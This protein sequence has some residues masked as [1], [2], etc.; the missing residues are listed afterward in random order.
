MEGTLYASPL[1]LNTMIAGTPRPIIEGIQLYEHNAAGLIYSFSNT[2][3]LI[4]ANVPEIQKKTNLVWISPD[5][6]VEP[7]GT[8]PD[9]YGCVSLSPDGTQIAM[10]ILNEGNSTDI[11]IW[12]IQD[13]K[14]RRFTFDGKSRDAV[15]T[16]DG[17]HIAFISMRDGVF[18]S[19]WKAANG[20]GD[21][22]T[23]VNS[24]IYANFPKSWA[25]DGK[26]LVLHASADEDFNIM[27][28][29]LEGDHKLEPLLNG[30]YDEMNPDISP[31]G[32]WIAYSS[33]EM[34]QN[35]VFVCSYPNVEEVKQQISTDGGAEPRW[36]Q[37]GQK[38]FYRNG[39]AIM[40]VSYET[41]PTFTVGGKPEIFLRGVPENKIPIFPLW[42]ING[43]G[44]KVLTIRESEDEGHQANT[45]RPK[46]TVVTNWFEELKQ[47][48]PVP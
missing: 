47:K 16:P 35:D 1:D 7:V 24:D 27:K 42:D 2:G 33:N 15:W 9:N 45:A 39:D 46:I 8:D 23:L 25:D 29:S 37:K 30:K 4:Y 31:D 34:G 40:V 5:D 10:D 44:S 26:T 12:D 13:S 6:K 17:S 14:A 21:V 22:E 18:N 48:V 32:R 3:T 20:K 11:Y 36:S 28:L 41:D 38:L 19:Y 43:N